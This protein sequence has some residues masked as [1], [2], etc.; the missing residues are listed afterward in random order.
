MQSLH[1][2]LLVVEGTLAQLTATP[3]QGLPP[4]TPFKSSYPTGP[5][6]SGLAGPSSS[7]QCSS[8]SYLTRVNTGSVLA[9]LPC[10]DRSCLVAGGS[11]SSVVISLDDTASIWLNELECNPPSDEPVTARSSSVSPYSTA[12]PGSSSNG[13]TRVKLEPTPVLLPPNTSSSAPSSSYAHRGLGFSR[14]GLSFVP[15]VPYTAFLPS[16]VSSSTSYGPPT[17]TSQTFTST[18]SSVPDNTPVTPS[19]RSDIPQVTS[20][21]LAYLPSPAGIRSKYLTSFEEAIRLHPTLNIRHFER[22][23]EAML[24]WNE[25][26]SEARS[27]S[28]L[29]K[30]VFFGAS[31]TK[32]A[33]ASGKDR[34]SAPT[35][36]LSFFAATCAAFALG[37]L[38]SRDSEPA[39]VDEETGPRNT[40]AG[41][42]SLSEQALGFF[43]KTNSY[44]IDSVTA[45]LL[46]VL[47]LMHDGHMN[48]SQGVFPLMGKMVNVARMMGL[49]IDP[50][51]FPGT[52]NLFDAETRR[53]VWWDV[54]YHDM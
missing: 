8:T 44:D 54:Y 43:E 30:E 23:I 33:S 45:M 11:G 28:E 25:S 42:F 35:P 1:N 5:T 20:T 51:E 18:F 24:S 38:L 2:R 17:A 16:D 6:Q 7:G 31:A 19:A 52:Y 12:K 14:S 40:P 22:R 32:R 47:Y 27:K 41:L 39:G 29:A 13:G 36:T 15:P 49:A 46:Q 37:A 48:V 3:Q 53:R 21:L 26:G 50:D 4:V 10:N 34:S 9:G